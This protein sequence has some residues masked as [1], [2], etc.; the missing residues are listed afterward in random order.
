MTRQEILNLID[1]RNS[2]THQTLTD[3]ST[4]TWDY[5]LGNV[6]D[7]TLGGNRILNITNA[8]AY[9]FGVLKV[10]QDSTGGRTLTVSGAY[11]NWV[12]SSGAGQYDLLSFYYD[13][14]TF[15]WSIE[16]YGT[17]TP[18]VAK[19]VL[20]AAVQS[21]SQINLSW[22]AVAFATGYVLQRDTDSSFASPTT[23]VNNSNVT[24][25]N[26]TGLSADTHYYYRLKAKATGF[27]D[28][29]YS[30]DDSTT[31]SSSYDSDAD[32]FFTTVGITDDTQK[33]AVNQLVLDLKAASIWTKM[34]AVYPF[35]G[36]DA[37]KHSYNLKNTSLFQLTFSGGWTHASTGSTPNGTNGYADTG[38]N[39]HDDGGNSGLPTNR[40]DLTAYQSFALGFYSRSNTAPS[41]DRTLFGSFKSTDEILWDN[42]STNRHYIVYGDAINDVVNPGTG[43]KRLCLISRTANNSAKAFRDGTQVGTTKTTTRTTNIQTR[44]NMWIGAENNNGTGRWWGDYECAFFFISD[45]LSDSEVTALNTAVNTYQTALSRNV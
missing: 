21:Y 28:S 1:A 19:P 41:T 23:L 35:V 43:Y 16:N 40:T 33:G 5:S 30:L 37:T 20:A 18:K 22:G 34:K 13:G 31:E 15:F 14:T 2:N 29:D 6:A 26:N 11:P 7:V 45:G 12:F 32:A 9:S 10:V 3:S 27:A 44:N 36:G 4:I 38:F 39:F 25:Y 24:S 17:I 8:P 42:Y